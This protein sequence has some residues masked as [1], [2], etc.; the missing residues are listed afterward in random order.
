MSWKERTCMSERREF[1]TTAATGEATL[2]ELSREYEISRKTAYK[3]LNRF[4]AEGWDG[5][6][7]RSR[8]PH[9]SPRRASPTAEALVCDLRRQHPKWGGRKIHYRLVGDGYADVPA[10]STI[11]DILERNGLLESDRRPAKAWQRFEAEKPNDLW[12]MDFKGHFATEEGRCH[13]LTILDDHSRF[14]ICLAA[15]ADERTETVRR[16]LVRAFERYGLPERML[17]DNGPPWGS[18]YV[19]QPHTH[20]TAWVI[21]LGIKVSHG[22]PYHPQTQGKEERFHASL[23]LEVLSGAPTWKGFSDVQGAFDAWQPVYNYRRPHQALAYAT[24]ASRYA[25]SPRPF[26]DRLPDIEYLPGDR[27]R[28]VQMGGEISFHGRTFHVGRAFCGESVALRAVGDGVWEVYYCHQRL[29]KLDL[30]S[31][32]TLEV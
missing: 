4:A 20:L 30:A 23:K 32:P 17:M 18:G 25:P 14:N 5:L 16:Q 21:R 2:S 1:V 8:R 13:P 28:K 12:Q 29:G 22:R 31:T 11:T 10:P 7:D 3:W 27:V 26:P 6:T 19:V 24:P 15:C 9:H